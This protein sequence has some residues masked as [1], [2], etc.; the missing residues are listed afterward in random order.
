MTTTEIL[1]ADLERAER[2]KSEPFRREWD[3]SNVATPSSKSDFLQNGDIALSFV[4]TNILQH[5]SKKEDKM[6]EKE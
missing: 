1:E 5:E 3:V 4:R 6:I 2:K